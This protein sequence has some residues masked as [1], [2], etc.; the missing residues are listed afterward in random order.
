MYIKPWL[1]SKHTRKRS[2]CR[3]LHHVL[4]HIQDI[5]PSIRPIALEI[6]VVIVVVVGRIFNKREG[7]AHK[8][9]GKEKMVCKREIFF[10]CVGQSNVSMRYHKD[11]HASSVMVFSPLFFVFFPSFSLRKSARTCKISCCVWLLTVY[12]LLLTGAWGC[13]WTLPVAAVIVILL[14]T[15]EW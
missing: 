12:K 15:T 11:T 1:I 3:V 7:R 6:S 13:T 9:D 8:R 10:V 5:H 14:T 2:S 4:N